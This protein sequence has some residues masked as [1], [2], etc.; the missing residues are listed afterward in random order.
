MISLP[1][2][3]DPSSE[4]CKQRLAS[5]LEGSIAGDLASARD[6]PEFLDAVASVYAKGASPRIVFG[7]VFLLGVLVQSRHLAICYQPGSMA[8]EAAKRRLQTVNA[9]SV[10]VV[11][12][13]TKRFLTSSGKSSTRLVCATMEAALSW[14]KVKPVPQQVDVSESIDRLKDL[15][16]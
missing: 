11:I 13:A 10:S 5:L 6:P 15:V 16:A 3:D 12:D 1:G 9:E 2:E 4:E 8:L 7:Y 14:N